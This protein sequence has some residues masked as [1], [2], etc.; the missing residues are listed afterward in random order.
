VEGKS[1]L[2]TIR[3]ESCGVG[4]IDSMSLWTNDGDCAGFR[5]KGKSLNLRG[6]ELFTIGGIGEFTFEEELFEEIC[7]VDVEVG[8]FGL[9]GVNSS[10]GQLA[11]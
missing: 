3:F 2:I 1:P 7:S 8:W 10:V 9:V 11:E 5:V 6:E 4:D